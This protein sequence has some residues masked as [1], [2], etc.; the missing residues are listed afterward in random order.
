MV[1]AGPCC[2]GKLAPLAAEA[3]ISS[4]QFARAN[5]LLVAMQRAL[6]DEYQGC[7]PELLRAYP[8]FTASR[9]L[10]VMGESTAPSAG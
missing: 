5:Q 6:D 8:D 1:G 7:R 4:V 2:A 3:V 9:A 10:W